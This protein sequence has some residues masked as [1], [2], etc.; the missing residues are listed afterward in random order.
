MAT[1]LTKIGI[2]GNAPLNN[3]GSIAQRLRDPG[4]IASTGAC[5]LR[6]NFV[7]RRGDW[8]S[9]YDRIV[10]SFLEHDI[11]IY[12][13]VGHEALAMDR[14]IGSTFRTDKLPTFADSSEQKAWVDQYVDRFH[15]IANRFAGRI[16]VFESFNEP[17]DFYGGPS[18]LIEKAAWFA[19]MQTHIY[20]AI[21]PQNPTMLLVTGPLNGGW[22]SHNS[23]RYYLNEMYEFGIQSLGWAPGKMPFD[24]IGYHIYVSEGQY[25]IDNAAER[26]NYSEEV[27]QNYATFLGQM[28]N[29]IG[30][31][32]GPHSKKLWIS[33]FGW[34]SGKI[35]ED[36][37]TRMVERGINIL[38]N[39][40]RVAMGT[41]F[42]A[43]DFG[44]GTMTY[45]LFREG[46]V[47]DGGRKKA[48]FKYQQML[49]GVRGTI[50]PSTD[51]DTLRVT[52]TGSGLRIR[53]Q[54]DYNGAIL[55][56]LQPGDALVIMENRE[57]AATKVGQ[58][59]EWVYLRTSSGIVGYCDAQYLA[60]YAYG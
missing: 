1:N 38:A 60:P 43:E 53:S 25:K 41:L 11:K 32:E 26:Y 44:G 55:A 20:N 35:S 30:H 59:G 10:D 8:L 42:C 28:W 36:F 48:W 4:P 54:P 18:A 40:D 2:T 57:E 14:P 15:A 34:E 7:Q 21:K 9:Q 58:Q 45:G 31:H 52:A 24:G 37:Q 33:E 19:Y 16:A 17:N 47:H 22:I 12:G 50:P 13:T 46:Q 29:V 51:N 5:W 6:L 49:D 23:A 27:E 3:D 56:Q 39:D